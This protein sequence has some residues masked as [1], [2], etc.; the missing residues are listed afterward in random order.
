MVVQSR[1]AFDMSCHDDLKSVTPH[2]LGCQYTD[3]VAFLWCKL[4]RLEALIPVIS[5]DAAALAVPLL[6]C[7]H[8]LKGEMR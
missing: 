8:T 6:G 1:R 5:D 2:S 3:L 7:R 4:S